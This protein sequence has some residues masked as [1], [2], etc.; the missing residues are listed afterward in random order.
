MRNKIFFA[1]DLH[2]GMPS[3]EKS[4]KREKIF[5]QWLE[6]IKMEAEVLYLVGDVFDFWFEYKH[7][8]PRGY[9]RVLGKLAELADLGVK[10]HLFI[11]NHDLW[12]TDYLS[13]ELSADLHTGHY[14]AT[15]WGKKMYIHHGDGLGPGDYGYKF[16]KFV[17]TFPP[18][19][20]LYGWLHPNIGV[21][22]AQFAS[23]LSGNYSKKDIEQPFYGEKEALLI[24]SREIAS[25]QPDIVAFVYG[26]R[27]ILKQFPVNESATCFYLGDW[28]HFFSYLEINEKG[29]E[30]KQFAMNKDC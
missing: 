9:I 29:M 2:L 30:L 26:H 11:G 24:H 20:W 3:G 16:I 1:S 21:P 5:V 15:H 28:I 17:F 10:I 13:T 12:Y 27:H 6:S 19:K 18:F 8:V 14:I 23:Q 7:A 22:L 25:Q 4:L